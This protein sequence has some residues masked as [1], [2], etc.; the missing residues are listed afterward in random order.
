M[1]A[2]EKQGCSST[3]IVERLGYGGCGCW[4]SGMIGEYRAGGCELT[5]EDQKQSSEWDEEVLLYPSRAERRCV[6]AW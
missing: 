5:V 1:S 6:S 2:D 4:V 3:M